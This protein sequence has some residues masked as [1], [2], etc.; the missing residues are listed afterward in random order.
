MSHYFSQDQ[1]SYSKEFKL[2]ITH[3]KGEFEL[4]SDSGVFSKKRLDKGSKLLIETCHIQKNQKVLDLG[5]GIGVIGL[6]VALNTNIDLTMSDVNIRALHLARKNSKNLN[7][8]AKIINSNL[9][10]NITE[11][12]D[13]ILSNPPYTAGRKT[14]FELIEQ[15]Y[16]H[17]KIGGSLQIVA[18]HNKGGK[19]L[20]E[21]IQKV[22]NNMTE[23][24]KGSGFRVYQGI[25]R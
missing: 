6:S 11:E 4:I 23:L 14:C 18:R 22:Y 5:C 24:G 12:F 8:K 21:K 13:V 9:F 7:I 17:L 20:G 16:K 3:K 1:T 2:Q 15:S 10:E 25:K 19:V